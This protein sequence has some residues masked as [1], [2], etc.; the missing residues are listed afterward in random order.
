MQGRQ[1]RDGQRGRVL[2]SEG[3]REGAERESAMEHQGGRYLGKEGAGRVQGGRAQQMW[4][5]PGK[6]GEG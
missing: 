1:G 6:A 2:R 3:A 5:A 4:R